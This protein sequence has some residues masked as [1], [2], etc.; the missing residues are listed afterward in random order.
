MRTFSEEMKSGS[1]EL[2]LTKPISDYEIIVGKYLSALAITLFALAPTIVYVFSLYFM[3]SPEI[4]I[5]IS[6]YIGI[7]LLSG[8]YIGLGIL[9]SS[10]SEHQVVSFII[11][12]L[13][14]FVLFLLNLE[15]LLTKMPNF[16]VNIFEY[17]G[18]NFH[19]SNIAR[20]V[21]DS[22]NVIYLLSGTVISVMLTRVSLE[23]R[24]W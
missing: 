18:P 10:L 20:G 14:M 6:T 19:F 12:F 22:R 8:F 3:G 23:R 5:I 7:I 4:G 1:I 9:I 16:L 24:K 15:W 13:L 21:I 11:S 2:L 17:L